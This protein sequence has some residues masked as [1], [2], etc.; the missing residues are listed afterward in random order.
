MFGIKLSRHSF[1]AYQAPKYL[2]PRIKPIA[3][4]EAIANYWAKR[5]L[6]KRIEREDVRQ[7]VETH[8][9]SHPLKH[10]A[11]VT[12]PAVEEDLPL[13]AVAR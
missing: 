4:T 1:G 8:A 3:V 10:G 2:L 5:W 11:R 6:S 7:E 9:L 13:F 12:L